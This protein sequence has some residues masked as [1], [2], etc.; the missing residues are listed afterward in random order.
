MT[1]R[2]RPETAT[3]MLMAAAVHPQMTRICKKQ[4]F[5]SFRCVDSLQVICRIYDPNLSTFFKTIQASTQPFKIVTISYIQVMLTTLLKDW[6]KE[7]MYVIEIK[8]TWD[9][10]HSELTKSAHIFLL[11]INMGIS[12][13]SSRHTTQLNQLYIISRQ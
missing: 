3:E 1:P 7:S 13:N 11:A 9:A 10:C 6:M 5:Q 2:L 4:T 8:G 12:C